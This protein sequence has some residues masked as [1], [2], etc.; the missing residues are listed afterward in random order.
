MP[1]RASRYSIG[2]GVHRQTARLSPGR[3]GV[4][5]VGIE[6]R[7]GEAAVN[8]FDVARS[9]KKFSERGCPLKGGGG[10][11]CVPRYHFGSD[12]SF[13]QEMLARRRVAGVLRASEPRRV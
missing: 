1:F 4:H 12:D 3:V 11:G 10:W 2:D 9:R 8:P 7:C 13:A 6:E 5:V